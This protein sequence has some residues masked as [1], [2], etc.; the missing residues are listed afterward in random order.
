VRA[1][2]AVVALVFAVSGPNVF[3]GV[4]FNRY[5][6]W[7]FPGLLALAA[8]G[9]GRATGLLARDDAPLERGLFRAGAGLLVLLGL[10]ST[11]R[12]AAVYAE[13]AGGT[14]RREIPT[15]AWIRANLPPGVGIANLAT[16]VEYLTGHRN[17]S[18]HG[19]TSPAFVGN[20]SAEREA[21]LLESLRRLPV[22]ERP[23]WLLLARSGYEGSPLLRAFTDGPPLFESASL[24]DDLVLYR[25][26]WD[27]L[28][29]GREPVLPAARAA[30]AG[31]SEVD[32]LDVCDSRDEG[33]HGYA[34]DSRRGEL[35]LAGSVSLDLGPEGTLA[36]GGRLILGGETF[37]VRTRPGQDL[38]IVLRTNRVVVAQ[39]MSA[40][41]SLAYPVELAEMGLAVRVDGELAARFTIPN[42][43]G[44][45]E[46]V[47]RIPA[48]RVRS[49][50]TAL[51][52]QGR[53]AAFRYWFYQ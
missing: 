9:L 2:L 38:V 25:A 40:R 29:R 5:L 46:H 10:L 43:P 53:Y 15:A 31:L 21:G 30:I 19:V 50:T 6:M 3:M 39:A 13:M 4:H 42:G 18:L 23:P 12:F 52:L 44:W 47:Q 17:L 36:D 16:S 32:R 49:A 33:A 34:Y 11:A 26:R 1:W 41:G 37:R 14:W 22:A 45:N 20:R 28:D 24:G 8:A 27:L 7:A 35:M 51:A 48:A